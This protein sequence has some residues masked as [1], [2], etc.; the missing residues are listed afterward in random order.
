MGYEKTKLIKTT[1]GANG[2]EKERVIDVWGFEIKEGFSR[3]ER[4]QMK[5]SLSIFL[6]LGRERGYAHL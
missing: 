1:V 3:R 2:S 6:A 4:S 5:E